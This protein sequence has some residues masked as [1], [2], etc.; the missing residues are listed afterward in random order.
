ME[1]KWIAMLLFLL[2]PF[3]VAGRDVLVL[4]NTGS[5]CRHAFE[6][7]LTETY[8]GGMGE[9]ARRMLPRK[10]TLWQGGWMRFKM[11]VDPKKQN[12]FT[13]RCWGSESDET[14]VM[15]FIEGKQVGYRHLG[16][17]D[18]LHRGNGGKPCIGRF[19]YYTL[20][21][22]LAYTQGKKE[23]SLEMRSYGKTWDYG[24]TFD[25]YQKEMDAPTIG[26]YKAYIHTDPYFV[27]HKGEKQ[28]RVMV[29]DAPLR[30]GPGIEVLETLKEQLSNR[31]RQIMAKQTPLGQ[32]EIWLLADAY[33][34]SWTPVYKRAEAV[35]KVVKGID[36]FY[37]KYVGNPAIIYTD[38][39]VY[40]GDWMTTCLLARSIRSLW[41]EV[42]G[43]L[44]TDSILGT[45]RRHAWSQLMQASLDY[46]TT[47]RRHYTNQSMIIDMAIYECNKALMQLNPQQ[48]LPEYQTL[49]YLYESLAL[50]PW[51][52]K[53]L[54]NGKSEKPLGEHYLQLTAK[55][56]T[57]EL[58]FVGYYGEVLDWVNHIYKVTSV[59]G[60]PGTGDAKI[61][62]QLLRI[63]DARY[64]FRYPALD[65]EG[66][67]C[68]RTEAV[69][70][71]RDGNHYPGDLMY[72]DR[73]TAWDATPLMT[74]ATTLD[75]RA[76]GIAQ[77]MLGDNQFFHM[78][79]RKLSDTG[80]IRAL[81]SCL[82]VPDEYEWLI[83]QPESKE[84]LPMSAA[85]PDYVFS[86]EEDGV[87]ALKN[88]DEIL[89]VSLYWR[90]RNGVN[91]LVKVHYITPVMDR[92]ANVYATD[93][94]FTDSGMKYTRPDWVNLGFVG[95][96]EWYDG[97]HSAHAGEVLP[98]ARIPEGM[99]FKPGDENIHAGKADFYYL[100]YGNYIIG[101][102]SSADKEEVLTIPEG[103]KSI[104]DLTNGKQQVTG[105]QLIV[106]PRTTVVLYLTR[107]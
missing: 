19:Y 47:H 46:G 12:Y 32:Q 94:K 33:S 79:Q 83:S 14:M 40:N 7:S 16:D 28:G 91:K 62:Q 37:K 41:T 65:D 39:S 44:D 38:G 85:A 53:V 77:Q 48:A 43:K 31:I 57:R 36:D 11:K 96:R 51:L 60:I 84:V 59:P 71:W 18:L 66:Y 49:R 93:V 4:G 29:A 3:S 58:G 90:A 81:Q 5:E 69:V 78:I 63:A 56:L 68:F 80:N 95:F 99:A 105:K 54:P 101:M 2:L 13:V 104:V 67:R 100:E 103:A 30:T 82:H 1:Q 15:L 17:Y 8:V 92:I 102:N 35:A 72:G 97:L 89:Y 20:P 73:G 10:D 26:F 76:I 9:T 42:E 34:V 45:S 87:L 27:P 70:G 24:N 61:K 64:S 107:K 86:D 23:V 21:L 50:A 75:K 106:Q 22:P 98:I 25:K 74:A 88:G 6:E 55:G 52:G